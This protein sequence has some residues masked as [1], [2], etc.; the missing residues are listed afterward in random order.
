[1]AKPAAV[2]DYMSKIRVKFTPDMDVLEALSII[3]EKD[4]PGGPVVDKL[5]NLVG[6]LSEK[7]CLSASLSASYHDQW[8]GRVAEFMQAEVLSVEADANIA[9]VAKLFMEREYK[10]LPVMQENQLVGQISRRDVLRALEQLRQE[11]Q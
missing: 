11:A 1:M 8:G 4:V 9:D 10:H 7:D 2:K 3:L 5:G 6:I